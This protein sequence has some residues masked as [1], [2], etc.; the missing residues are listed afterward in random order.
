METC[1]S[2]EIVR[3][4]LNIDGQGAGGPFGVLFDDRAPIQPVMFITKET[5]IH[6]DL[7]TRF[8]EA[9]SGAFRAV[10]P[11][12]GHGDFTDEAL[13]ASA[14]NPM[15]AA[16]DVVDVSRGL[17]GAFFDQALAEESDWDFRGLDAKT[18]VFINVF[19]LGGEPQIPEA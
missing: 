3:A 4:C 14:L 2:N 17:I 1:R 19:P 16:G 18:N 10:L 11:S 7:V 6:P 13:L 5:L 12:A 15:A 8:E 9:G